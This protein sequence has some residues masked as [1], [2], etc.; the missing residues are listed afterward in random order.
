ME[1]STLNNIGVAWAW[2]HC[3]IAVENLDM[4]VNFYRHSFG[5]EP[6][7][8]AMDM[9]DLIQSVTGVPGLRADLIQCQ[10]PIS[11]Q[12]LELIRFRNLPANFDKDAPITPG[13]S[14]NAFLVENLE[15][16][17]AEVVRR[18]GRLLGQIT[19]FSEGRAAYLTDGAGNAIELEE[20]MP[21][22]PR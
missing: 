9:T 17:I 21:E 2:H 5:F 4:A 19:E 13:R 11:G 1:G 15:P 22:I 16:A 10:S 18:G 8:E 6:T 20:S 12:I 3:G 7:F 14:H